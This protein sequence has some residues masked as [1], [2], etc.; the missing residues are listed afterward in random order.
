[1][2]S[3][4]CFQSGAEISLTDLLALEGCDAAFEF[5]AK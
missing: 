2:D 3:L 1:M 5:S 4:D